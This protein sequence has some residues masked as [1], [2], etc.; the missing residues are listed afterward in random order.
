M[1]ESEMVFLTILLKMQ[2]RRGLPVGP[3]S[4]A[5]LRKRC[6]WRT[7]FRSSVVVLAE[8]SDEGSPEEI[9]H[10]VKRSGRV[11]ISALHFHLFDKCL[12]TV[13]V[14]WTGYIYWVGGVKVE[15]WKR[16]KSATFLIWWIG[17]C[18]KGFFVFGNSVR[19]V[20]VLLQAKM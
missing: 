15:V 20:L 19:R 10:S 12:Q 5:S 11:C 4:N 13:D 6:W 18:C 9:L 7:N 14:L 3:W 8:A 1:S 16:R 17:R 2:S